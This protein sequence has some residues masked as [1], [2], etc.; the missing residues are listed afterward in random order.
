MSSEFYSSTKAPKDYKVRV[1][2]LPEGQGFK[3][4]V[5]DVRERLIRRTSDVYETPGAAAKSGLQWVEKNL[6]DL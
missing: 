2:L 6:E 4:E 1:I 3:C 5:W